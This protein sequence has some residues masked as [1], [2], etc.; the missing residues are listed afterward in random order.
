MTEPEDTAQDAEL[1]SESAT[2]EPLAEAN[3]EAG[4]DDVA[5]DHRE[6]GDTY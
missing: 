6:S 1:D 2:D 5:S 4:E 3:Q